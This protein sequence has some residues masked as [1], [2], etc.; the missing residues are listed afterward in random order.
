VQIGSE[1]TPI[2]EFGDWRIRHEYRDPAK[3]DKS[4]F[5]E[6]TAT[7]RCSTENRSSLR[8]QYG[9]PEYERFG[10]RPGLALSVTYADDRSFKRVEI[11][12]STMAFGKEPYSAD[13]TIDASAAEQVVDEVLTPIVRKGLRP[14][15]NSITGWFL[16]ESSTG[17]RLILTRVSD[18]QRKQLLGYSIEWK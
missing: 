14:G 10:V 8:Q 2:E 1:Q 9:P 3:T 13:N 6:L 4:V 15:V 7:S 5:V 18:P 16:D 11:R 12:R 17:E